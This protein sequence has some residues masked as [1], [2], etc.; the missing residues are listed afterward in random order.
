VRP[1]IDS[2]CEH[3]LEL[4]HLISMSTV[5]DQVTTC[6]TFVRLDQYY[7]ESSRRW[8]QISLGSDAKTATAAARREQ[9]EA[10][11][12]KSR[13]SE[14]PDMPPGAELDPNALPPKRSAGDQ[15]FPRAR[16][17]WRPVAFE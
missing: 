8:S 3:Y 7:T 2:E 6:S 12:A 1:N 17:T 5:I 13:A 16:V 4:E 11:N 9:Q 14:M 10:L 15:P